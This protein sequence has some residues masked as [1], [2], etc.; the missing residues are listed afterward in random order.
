MH[1]NESTDY[2]NKEAKISKK[3]TTYIFNF[4]TFII[5]AE[6]LITMV[7]YF[8]MKERIL[9]QTNSSDINLTSSL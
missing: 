9:S 1:Y 4:F 6:V 3:K 5:N 7:L 2:M 8:F